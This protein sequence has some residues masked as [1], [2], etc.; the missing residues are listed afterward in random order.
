M[1]YR[2][3][4]K[5]WERE[6]RKFLANEFNTQLIFKLINPEQMDW[7]VFLDEQKI[8]E[9]KLELKNKKESCE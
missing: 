5:K 9:V 2:Y 7:I 4:G 1:N 6:S 3:L 8:A